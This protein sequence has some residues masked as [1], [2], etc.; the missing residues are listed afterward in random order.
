MQMTVLHIVMIVSIALVSFVALLAIVW[1]AICFIEELHIGERIE[2][3]AVAK[4]R[5]FKRRYGK[6]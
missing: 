4:A 3:I 2:A 1:F 6:R 5:K